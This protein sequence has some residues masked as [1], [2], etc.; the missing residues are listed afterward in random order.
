MAPRHDDAVAVE[1]RRIFVQLLVGHD[2][3]RHGRVMQ[4]GHDVGVRSEGPPIGPGLHVDHRSAPRAE[5]HTASIV[6]VLVQAEPNLGVIAQP[7]VGWWRRCATREELRVRQLDALVGVRE[8]GGDGHEERDTG[9]LVGRNG[10]GGGHKEGCAV[11]T[12]V[13]TRAEGV[14]ATREIRREVECCGR[15]PSGVVEVAR[16]EV[17][18]VVVARLGRWIL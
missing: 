13:R 14:D 2:V 10:R 12:M 16:V 4:E 7:E 6:V 15:V 1:G 11:L 18:G 17:H 5:H 3:E 9:P 8:V